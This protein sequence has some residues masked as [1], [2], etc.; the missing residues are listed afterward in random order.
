MLVRQT[1]K[2]FTV[3]SKSP[4]F[5]TFSLTLLSYY[6]RGLWK[7]QKLPIITRPDIQTDFRSADQENVKPF[8]SGNEN[9]SGLPSDKMMDETVTLNASFSTNL[10]YP[11]SKVQWVR[12]TLAIERAKARL[13]ADIRAPPTV[14]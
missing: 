7:T 3:H 2:L 6:S 13:G 10:D 1:H 12:W 11:A 14:S 5:L 4:E 8:P 9:A